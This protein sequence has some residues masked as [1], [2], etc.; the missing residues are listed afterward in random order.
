M[1]TENMA[2]FFSLMHCMFLGLYSFP[3]LFC[4]RTPIGILV[5]AENP[6]MQTDC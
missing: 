3:I 6:G 4:M 5:I 2:I 1:E